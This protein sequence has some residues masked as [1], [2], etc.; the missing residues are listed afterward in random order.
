MTEHYDYDVVIV[1]GGIAGALAGAKLAA[2]GRSVLILEAGPELVHPSYNVRKFYG[3]DAKVPS[4]PWTTAENET[5]SNGD[6]ANATRFVGAPTVL[7]TGRPIKKDQEED[8]Y[9]VQPANLSPFNTSY[10]RYGGGT[11]NHWLGTCLRHIPEDLQLKTRFDGPDQSQETHTLLKEARDWPITYEELE[12]W[13]F[14]AEAQIGVSGNTEEYKYFGSD[15]PSQPVRANP[16]PMTQIPLTTSDQRIAKSIDGKVPFG[17]VSPS[18]ISTPQARLSREYPNNNDVLTHK[19]IGPSGQF[20]RYRCLGN[21]SCI[22][23]CPVQAKFDGTVA[24]RMATEPFDQASSGEAALYPNRREAEIKYNA[25][26][27]NV[28]VKSDGSDNPPIDHILY[29]DA[30]DTTAV[31]KKKVTARRYIIAA[32]ALESPRLLKMSDKWTDSKNNEH[33]VANSSTWVGC[34]LMDHVIHLVWGLAKEPLYTLRGP[35]STAGIGDFRISSDAADRSLMAGFR[36]EIGND[37]WNWATGAPD[38]TVQQVMDILAG[39]EGPPPKFEGPAFADGAPFANQTTVTD[40]L[41]TYYRTDGTLDENDKPTLKWYGKDLQKALNAVGTRMIRM[42]AEPEALPEKASEVVVKG[43]PFEDRLE[44]G[45][46]YD[47]TN[48]DANKVT[49]SSVPD[50]LGLPR[51][52]VNYKISDY[53]K[54][55]FINGG[56]IVSKLMSQI[57]SGPLANSIAGPGG[58]A[59]IEHEG[60]LYP[61]GGAGHAAGTYLM[62]DDPSDSVVDKNCRS[63]DHPNLFMLGSGTFPALGTANPTL[64]IAALALRA[65]DY[66]NEDLGA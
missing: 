66:I 29:F 48:P 46:S 58:W 40:V 57:C 19:L 35:L 45:D 50:G 65:G 28:V 42:A 62:G 2:E 9:L 55:G 36:I 10:E 5:L 33:E 20:L 38:S 6:N 25:V 11:T 63:H 26:A 61:Y 18:V 54:A 1:G 47:A 21:T 49:F 59:V 12:P 53:S 30:S 23:L 8:F 3:A 64:T 37:G 31:K 51:P 52:G 14:Q 16:Y 41:K 39:T 44:I 7:D 32:H 27:Y 56:K 15:S 24:I 34:G 4:S 60:K 17:S 43:T 13:Y 22:P